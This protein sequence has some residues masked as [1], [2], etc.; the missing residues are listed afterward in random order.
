M[1]VVTMADRAASVRTAAG[2]RSRPLPIRLNHLLADVWQR[3]LVRR[4]ERD[5]HWL[6]H[7]DVVE[8]FQ[9]SSRG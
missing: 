6:D 5:V 8:D 7:P 2:E 1:Y 4:V 3:Y 9:R